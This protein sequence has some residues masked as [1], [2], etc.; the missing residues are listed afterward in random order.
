MFRLSGQFVKLYAHSVRPDETLRPAEPRPAGLIEDGG[1]RRLGLFHGSVSSTPPWCP[2]DSASV[3]AT[4]AICALT[5]PFNRFRGRPARHRPASDLRILFHFQLRW[6]HPQIFNCLLG[7]KLGDRGGVSSPTRSVSCTRIA[8]APG[9]QP[10]STRQRLAARGFCGRSGAFG[11][12]FAAHDAASIRPADD[13][14]PAAD[15]GQT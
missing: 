10:R 13:A 1:V 4:V 3:R 15:G 8:H 11:R 5:S 6:A 2:G 7:L 12:A 14:V 9:V